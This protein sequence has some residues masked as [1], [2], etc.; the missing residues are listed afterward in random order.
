MK[1]KKETKK[2][3]LNE[4]FGDGRV[5][6]PT[7]LSK[8]EGTAAY[9]IDQNLDKINACKTKEELIALMQQLFDDAGLRTP[10]T[11]KFFYLLKSKRDFNSALKLVYDAMLKAQGLGVIREGEKKAE[12]K[13][14]KKQIENA[15]KYWQGVLEKMD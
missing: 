14:T 10:W 8:K 4:G 15:I 1:D 11:N 12:K 5:S 3:K 13:Y 2:T 6:I 7:D 9:I